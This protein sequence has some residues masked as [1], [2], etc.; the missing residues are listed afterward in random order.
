M[1][2]KHVLEKIPLIYVQSFGLKT[3]SVLMY[4]YGY[5]TEDKASFVRSQEINTKVNH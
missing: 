4:M 3:L 2:S 5:Q 1:Q